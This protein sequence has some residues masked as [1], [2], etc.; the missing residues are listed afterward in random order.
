MTTNSCSSSPATW[1]WRDRHRHSYHGSAAIEAYERA[2]RNPTVLCDLNMPVSDGF[3]LMEE[4]AVK[5]FIGG[6][7]LFSG[8][9]DRT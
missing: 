2:L 6:V 9:D 8:M 4:L 3:Q 7:I 5:G 1:T